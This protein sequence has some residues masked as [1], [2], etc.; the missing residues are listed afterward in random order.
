MAHQHYNDFSYSKHLNFLSL[1]LPSPTSMFFSWTLRE[2]LTAA[3]YTISYINNDCI[4]DTYD[5]IV[6]GGNTTIYR[7]LGLQEGTNY[8]ITLT[9]YLTDGR[10]GSGFLTSSTMSV[11]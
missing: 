3:F 2:D 5:D 1:G 9:A 11:G 7:L 4:N 8:T 6:I 10:Y